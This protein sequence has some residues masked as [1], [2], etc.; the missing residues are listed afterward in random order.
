MCV[1]VCVLDLESYVCVCVCGIFCVLLCMCCARVCVRDSPG[2][3]AS[4]TLSSPPS[5]VSVKE[6]KGVSGVAVPVRVSVLR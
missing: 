1:S 3:A 5:C 4:Y 2:G 6:A